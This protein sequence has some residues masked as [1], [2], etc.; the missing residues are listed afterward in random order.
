M[1]KE[2]VNKYLNIVRLSSLFFTKRYKCSTHV[3]IQTY[4]TDTLMRNS[5]LVAEKWFFLL[6]KL[7]IA[8]KNL[9]VQ[10]TNEKR[11]TVICDI[12]NAKI[13]YMAKTTLKHL[14]DSWH[15]GKRQD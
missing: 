12:S 2:T 13:A 10:K 14:P 3:T 7:K 6:H 11:Q 8:L 5:L 1:Q 9:F 4:F 15:M